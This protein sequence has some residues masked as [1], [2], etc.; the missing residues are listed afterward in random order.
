MGVQ[1]LYALKKGDS[2]TRPKIVLHVKIS[3]NFVQIVDVH[4]NC[5]GYDCVRKWMYRSRHMKFNRQSNACI[6][7]QRNLKTDQVRLFY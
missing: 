3:Q 2:R 7:L 4:S 6:V 1:Y 5:Q